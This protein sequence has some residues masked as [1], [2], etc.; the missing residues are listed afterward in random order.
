MKILFKR[1]LA[2]FY[3]FPIFMFFVTWDI[4]IAIRNNLNMFRDDIN[5]KQ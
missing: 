4:F 3:L 2:I 5:I 1:L